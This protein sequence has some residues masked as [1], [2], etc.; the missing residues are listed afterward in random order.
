VAFGGRTVSIDDV[1]VERLLRGM[2]GDSVS[3]RSATELAGGRYNI[4]IGITVGDGRRL[5]L[6][7]AP[8]EPQQFRSEWHLMRN[9][10]AAAPVIR[11]VAPIPDTLAYDF[12]HRVIDRDLL[13]Q[14]WSPGAPATDALAVGGDPAAVTIWRQIGDILARFHQRVGQ[15]FGRFIGRRSDNWS[16][17]LAATFDSL[18]RDFEQVAL[19]P[20]PI[21]RCLRT[22][23]RRR[24]LLDAVEPRLVHGDLGPGNVMVRSATDPTIIGLIDCDRSWWGDPAADWTFYLVN[25]RRPQQQAAFWSGYGASASHADDGAGD[26]RSWLYL[27][28]SEAEASLELRRRGQTAKLEASQ[29]SLTELTTLLSVTD[30]PG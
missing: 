28:R 9:E 3:I 6:R 12:S 16:D 5:V 8:T 2:L 29:K 25:R 22:I 15:D 13:L 18:G 24:D 21:R 26:I 11:S 14:S 1:S 17:Q 23:S 30:Q 19:D 10:L 20:T 4:T 27:A 7:A